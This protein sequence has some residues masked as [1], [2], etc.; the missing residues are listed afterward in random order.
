MELTLLSPCDGPCYIVW[1]FFWLVFPCCIFFYPFPCRIYVCGYIYTYTCHFIFLMLGGSCFLSKISLWCLNG[2]FIFHVIT[3]RVEFNLDLVSFLS[4]PSVL[5]SFVPIFLPALG[6]MKCF[7]VFSCTLRWA[8]SC[9][10]LPLAHASSGLQYASLLCCSLSC[11]P[12]TIA[13]LHF[14]PLLLVL[15]LSCILV[16]HVS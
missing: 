13:F 14:V 12:S 4:V 7:G 6:V 15:L 5:W 10:S 2:E 8:Y 3:Y 1:T 11:L 16:L 9:P